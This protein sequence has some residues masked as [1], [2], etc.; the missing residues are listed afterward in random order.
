MS[1]EQGQDRALGGR[2]AMVLIAIVLAYVV[3]GRVGLTLAYYN[4][5]ATLVWAPSGIALAALWLVAGA[6]MANPPASA[7]STLSIGRT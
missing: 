2:D 5:A 7:E 1:E 6:T 4:K 3:T